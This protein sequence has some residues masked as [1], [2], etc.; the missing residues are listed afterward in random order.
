MTRGD[1]GGP[2]NG[3]TWPGEPGS[4]PDADYPDVELG[5][6]NKGSRGRGTRNGDTRNGDSGSSDTGSSDTRNSRWLR[7]PDR[8]DGYSRPRRR[9]IPRRVKWAAAVVVIGLIFRRAV[10][11]LVLM[12]LSATLHFIGVNVHLPK[13]SLAWPWQTITSGTTTNTDVGPW[14]LQK[15]EG[16]SKPALGQAN[17][18]F[19]F[20]HKVSKNIGFLPCW[21]AG[22]F[23]AVGHASATVDLNP[24]AAWWT[25][26]SGHYKLQILDRPADGKAGLAAV[27]MVLP[28]PQLPQSVNDVTIDNIPSAP[29]STQHSWTYPGVA[30]GLVLRPQFSQSVLYSEAQQI[31]FYRSDHSPQITRPLINSAET[32][33][34][35][36]IKNNFIQP[37]LNAFGYKLKQF[38]IQWAA[39]K[40]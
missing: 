1:S 4:D 2:A 18:N 37:T 21:Y 31:A 19:L 5:G 12:A 25:P 17:F 36:T 23:Y 13:L 10:A 29:V 15:I 33:A 34:T 28:Q 20:T 11:S 14:V 22:T 26:S 3:T 30:C 24:G 35:Q 8:G 32:E 9:R 16:I 7:R 39:T 27:T 6:A 38:T 40:T